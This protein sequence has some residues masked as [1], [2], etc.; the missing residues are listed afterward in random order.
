MARMIPSKVSETTESYAERL[1]FE[2]ISAE[3]PDDWI[4]LHS[5][6]V[7][8]FRRMPWTEVGFVPDG[9]YCLEV[10]GGNLQRVGGKWYQNEHEL[11]RGPFEQVVPSATQLHQFLSHRGDQRLWIWHHVLLWWLE[12]QSSSVSRGLWIHA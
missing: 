7:A 1:M 6:G 10:K 12:Y 2:K 4:A 8:E 9:V 5:L 3:L 11:D